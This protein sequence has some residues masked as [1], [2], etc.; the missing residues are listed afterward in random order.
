MQMETFGPNFDIKKIN[1]GYFTIENIHT[2]E[3]RTFRIHKPRK[4][5]FQ[6]G[7]QIVSLFTGSNNESSYTAFG[8][9]NTDGIHIWS[10]FTNDIA[11]SQ[12]GKALFSLLTLGNDSPYVTKGYRFRESEKCF[13]CGKTLTTPESIDTGIGPICAE[14]VL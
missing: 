5:S 13:V 10:R 8:F 4:S 1:K 9:L 7:T 11:W 2:G 6:K 3:Y 14:R 12:Y